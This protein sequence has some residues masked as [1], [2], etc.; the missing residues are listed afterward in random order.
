MTIE[1]SIKTDNIRSVD[2]YKALE[3]KPTLAGID[4][5]PRWQNMYK[6]EVYNPTAKTDFKM[7]G[8]RRQAGFA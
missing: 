8:G 7:L 5:E 6:C 4:G 3:I 2:I 1:G